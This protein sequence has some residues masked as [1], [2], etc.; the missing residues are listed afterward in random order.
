M[1]NSALGLVPL[2]PSLPS[3]VGFIS[4]QARVLLLCS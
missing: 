1:C 3:M 2:Q 4:F